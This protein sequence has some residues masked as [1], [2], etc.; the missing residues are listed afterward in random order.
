MRVNQL[1][2]NS[3]IIMQIEEFV[4]N[5]KAF[6]ESKFGSRTGT[7]TSYANAL[8]YLFEYLGFN[9][10]DETAVLTV[11]SLDPDIRDKHCVFY[12]SILDE[13]SSKGRSSYIENG[14]LK[15]AIPALYEF[16][17]EHPLSHDEQADDVL[18]DAINDNQIIAQFNRD[19][20]RRILPTA[21]YC[22][23]TYDIRRINGTIKDAAKR[24]YSGR[25][26]EKYFLSF[27]KDCLG[28]EQGIDFIDVSNNKEYGYD[29]RLLGCGIEVK[30]IKNGGFYLTDNEIARLE[31]SETHLILVDIDNGIWLLKNNSTWLKTI[32]ANIKSIRNFC[33]DNYSQ[34][35]LTD[36]R[37]DIN[38]DAEKDTTEISGLSKQEIKDTLM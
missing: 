8:K 14:F 28:L 10:V 24:I 29:I 19:E 37:I 17:N 9:K 21:A 3:R 31:H 18:L 32:I 4:S 25:K 36:I 26:A 30:N 2:N 12:N 1:P 15:A 34:L 13:F 6:C 23:H 20:L 16:L 33:K 11:K 7:A 22:E 27:L 35:D 38:S 5:Y